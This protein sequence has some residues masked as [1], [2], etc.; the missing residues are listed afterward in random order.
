MN[1]PIIGRQL[2]FM[3]ANQSNRPALLIVG[4]MGFARP[5]VGNVFP[6]VIAPRTRQEVVFTV[7]DTNDWAIWVNPDDPRGGEL[8]G[9]HDIR[10]CFGRVALGIEIGATGDAGWSAGDPCVEQ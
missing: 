4:R 3:V 5:P 1:V 6:P 10:R 2:A 9:W 8:M 7:P